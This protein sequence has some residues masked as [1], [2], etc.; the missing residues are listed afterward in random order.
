MPVSSLGSNAVASSQFQ[1]AGRSPHPVLECPPCS[2]SSSLSS[3]SS[4]PFFPGPL[5]WFPP[6]GQRSGSLWAGRYSC[7]L[8]CEHHEGGGGFGWVLPYSLVLQ[9]VAPREGRAGGARPQGLGRPHSGSPGQDRR[10][11]PS[12][13][14]VSPCQICRARGSASRPAGPSWLWAC[15]G[16]SA[17]ALPFCAA[18]GCRGPFP[19]C[20]FPCLCP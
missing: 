9:H 5:T 10:R 11:A 18:R 3:G 7:T 16:S 15:C 1:P 8:G 4:K 20:V 12:L 14:R 6:E 19:P 2:H 17:K 13:P